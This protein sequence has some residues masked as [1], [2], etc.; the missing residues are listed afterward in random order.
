MGGKSST[1]RKT[2]ITNRINTVIKNSNETMT[3]IINKT[4]NNATT[5]LANEQLAEIKSVNIIDQN[6]EADEINIDGGSFLLSAEIINEMKALVN[7]AND[8]SLMTK[9][10]QN[11]QK[12]LKSS[13]SQDQKLKQTLDSV[14]KLTGIIGNDC[15]ANN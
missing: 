1:E 11:I 13:I 6:V 12:E 5:E 7:I 8:T 14:S 3:E 4:I 15:E 10:L 2:E 9:L